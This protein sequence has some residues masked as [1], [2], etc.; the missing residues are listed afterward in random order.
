[1]GHEF[2]GT[3]TVFDFNVTRETP[4]PC[5]FLIRH[6][7]INQYTTVKVNS[8]WFHRN[9]DNALQGHLYLIT[10]TSILHGYTQIF[11]KAFSSWNKSS[12]LDRLYLVKCC[13]FNRYSPWLVFWMENF[14]YL[15]TVIIWNFCNNKQNRSGKKVTF[16]PTILA[17]ELF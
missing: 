16:K 2:I 12:L 13:H 15:G 10:E 8:F 14:F 6:F 11:I 7:L 5:S 1:M 17:I 4:A 9:N 3:A